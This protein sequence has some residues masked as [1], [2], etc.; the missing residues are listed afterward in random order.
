VDDV[1]TQLLTYEDVTAGNGYVE[2][3]PGP[4]LGVEL[5]EDTVRKYTVA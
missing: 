2:V 3:I 4:G 5:D 1:T